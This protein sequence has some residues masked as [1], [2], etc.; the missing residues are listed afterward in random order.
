VLAS[1]H[2][3]AFTVAPFGVAYVTPPVGCWGEAE[4][5]LQIW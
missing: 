5:R 1:L 3:E 2:G 4:A